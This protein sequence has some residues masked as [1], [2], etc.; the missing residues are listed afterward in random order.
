MAKVRVDRSKKRTGSPK[1]AM[2]SKRRKG[3]KAKSSPKRRFQ[4]KA[5]VRKNVHQ[6]I[7]TEGMELPAAVAE[8]KGQ[9][10]REYATFPFL[11]IFPLAMMRMFW[12]A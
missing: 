4:A 6:T 7:P 11:P 1:S 5:R 12:G 8:Q 10:T 3:I 9:R 2:G